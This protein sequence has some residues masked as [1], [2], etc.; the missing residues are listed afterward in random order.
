METL[1]VL[2]YA[3]FCWIIFKVFKIP[4]NKWSLTT[5]VLGGVI[6]LSVI[7][8]GNGILPSRVPKVPEPIL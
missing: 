5:A 2:T 4:V 1:M 6:M 3:T 7:S 8:N